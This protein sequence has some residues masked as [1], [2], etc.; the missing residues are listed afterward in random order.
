M[1]ERRLSDVGGTPGGL[2]HFLM[3]FVMACVGGYLLLNQV[4][5]VGSYWMFYGDNAFGITLL[6]LLF[7]I[8]ILFWNGRSTIGWLLTVGGALFIAGRGDRQHAHL[9]PTHQPVQHH[10]HAGA[11]GRRCRTGGPLAVSAPLRIRGATPW[12]PANGRIMLGAMP[13]STAEQVNALCDGLALPQARTKYGSA[14]ML[15]PPERAGS[16]PA[17]SPLRLL[18]PPA[19]GRNPHPALGFQPHPGQPGPRR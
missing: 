17:V 5:V 18:R 4:T 1:E 13:C 8:G 9:L 19:G 16:R 10:R 14:K 6:P 15:R 3:G 7:G 12:T 2:G 11:A